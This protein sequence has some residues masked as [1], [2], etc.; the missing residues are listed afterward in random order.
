MN[1]GAVR[2]CTRCGETKAATREFFGSAPS[3]KTLKGYC[4]A[5]M[6]KASRERDKH[7]PEGRKTRDAKRAHAGNGARR[8]FPLEIKQKLW[9][10]QNGLCLCCFE[11]IERPEEGEV[12]HMRPLAKGGLDHRSNFLLAHAKCNREKHNKTLPEHW[13]WRVKVGLDRENLGHKHGLL[14]LW[15]DD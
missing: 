1:L 4:R 10:R 6:N 12:D 11:Q 3:G 5:C 15:N 2:T 14:S 13:E 7:N 9:K 8:S